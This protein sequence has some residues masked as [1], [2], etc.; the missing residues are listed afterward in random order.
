MQVGTDDTSDSDSDLTSVTSSSS[1]VSD[2]SSISDSAPGSHP[3]QPTQG[4]EEVVWA[5]ADRGVWGLTHVF[6]EKLYMTRDLVDGSALPENFKPMPEQGDQPKGPKK[7]QRAE[8]VVHVQQFKMKY[9]KG[10]GWCS[11][12]C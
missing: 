5:K 8:G 6:D 10:K 3:N 9:Q 12:P 2:C 4:E 7:K 11:V 1:D